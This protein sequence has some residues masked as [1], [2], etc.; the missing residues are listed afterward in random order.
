MTSSTSHIYQKIEKY[1]GE[2]V[3]GGIDGCVTTF[4]VV[5]GSVGANL[6]SSIIIILGF[7][8]LLADGFAMSVGA[9]LSAKTEKDN[10]LKYASKQEDIDQL[11][12]NFNPLGKSIVTYISFLLIGIFPLLAYVFDYISPIKANVFLYS[13]I[14]TGIGFIIVGSL[15]SYI[16]H[17]AIW[18]GVAETLLLGILAAIVSYYVGDFIEGIIS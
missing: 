2:F 18:K 9:Y 8:N 13:S 1:L 15:K 12:R 11:E 3:Y 10:G 14:C 5:A 4:A 16:N 17:I 6:D 7:A